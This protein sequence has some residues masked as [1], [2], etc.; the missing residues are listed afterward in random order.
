MELSSPGSRLQTAWFEK[1]WSRDVCRK[2]NGAGLISLMLAIALLLSACA[3]QLTVPPH[4]RPISAHSLSMLGK[5]GM[6]P[7]SPMFIRIFK[8]ESELEIW[9]QRADGRFYLFRTYPI[10]NWSGDLGP[11]RRVG[12][13]QAPEGFYTVAKWQLNPNS[14]FHLSFNL[15]YPNAYDSANGRTGKFLMVHGKCKSAGCYAMTD[16]LIEEIYALAREAFDGG[17]EKF[18]VHAF[19]FRMTDENMKRNRNSRHYRFWTMLKPAYDFF[20]QT[21]LPPKIAICNRRY[22]VNVEWNGAKLDPRGYCPRFT[23]PVVTPFVPAP[24]PV[25]QRASLD[26]STMSGLT[27]DHRAR[28]LPRRLASP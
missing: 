15:G 10:C 13:K 8:Q 12:D 26:H 19:P 22:F 1:I 9:K 21:R 27:K 5:K 2:R 17:Q 14:Q 7:K 16:A 18:E 28:A 11:K 24:Q 23:H 3:T 4:L 20:E 25:G 6:T